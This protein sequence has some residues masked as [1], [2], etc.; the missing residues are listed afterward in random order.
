[1]KLTEV[2]NQV[3]STHSNRTL[4]PK[5]RG[6]T[7]SEPHGTFSKFDRIISPKTGLRRYKNIEIIPF[8][9]QITMD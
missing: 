7:F 1:M 5:I 8:I 3:D 9:Y 6:Y 2:M 4:Y